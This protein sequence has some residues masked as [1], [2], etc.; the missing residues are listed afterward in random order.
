MA[1][2][3]WRHL[4]FFQKS[5]NTIKSHRYSLSKISMYF[6][7][8]VGDTQLLNIWQQQFRPRVL[9]AFELTCALPNFVDPSTPVV[10]M[11]NGRR[12]P[13]DTSG[14]ITY[15]NGNR[16]MIFSE[17]TPDDRGWYTCVALDNSASYTLSLA[18]DLDGYTGYSKLQTVYRDIFTP[19]IFAPLHIPVRVHI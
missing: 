4:F 10:W 6:T 15:R 5:K 3:D 14:R 9:G 7:I 12:M 2:E 8:S 18:V 13:L 1:K 19:F 16:K 11:K 17:I